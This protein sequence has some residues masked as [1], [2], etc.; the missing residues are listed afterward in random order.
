MSAPARCRNRNTSKRL[1]RDIE[2]SLPSV[3]GRR[4]SSV[5]IGGGTPS[6]FSPRGD[7]RAALGRARAP[8]ARAGRG[9]HPGSESR[10][11]GGGALPRLPRAPGVNRISIG[12]QS[13][14]ERM[15]AALGRIHSARRGAPRH[16][17]GA[18]Q[19]R[20]REHRPHVRA[21]GAELPPW[22]RPTS[23]Q[24]L[25]FGVPHVSAYQLTIE[26]NTVFWSRPPQLPEH[27]LA[28]DMQLACRGEPCGAAATSITRPPRSRAPGSAAGTTST[29]GN[30]ATTSASAR[31]RTARS[32]S[33]TASRAMRAPSSPAST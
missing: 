8:D 25:S 22:R 7:R 27:D 14:D 18:C 21:A 32:A 9:N 17:G 6:L 3:W 1:M 15:L 12:V 2:A 16:R 26:P 24:A 4:M 19:L 10:H 11:R 13:F 29:T 31:A 5:F 23:K 20:Q 30:S 33:R 28:A